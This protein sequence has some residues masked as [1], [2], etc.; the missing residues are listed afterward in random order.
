MEA[1]GRLVNSVSVRNDQQDISRDFNPISTFKISKINNGSMGTTTFS[2][3]K[4]TRINDLVLTLST[5]SFDTSDLKNAVILNYELYNSSPTKSFSDV[6]FGIFNDWDIGD[7][8]NNSSR[9]NSEENMLYIYEDSPSNEDIVSVVALNKTSSALAI[10]NNF[11]GP[12]SST[13]FEIN[14]EFTRSEKRKSLKAGTE[15][16]VENNVD[17]SSVVASGPYYIAPNDKIS[18]GF[19]YA[20]GNTLNELISVVNAARNLDLIEISDINTNP[21]LKFPDDF[22]VFEN[23]PNPFN[24]KT[25]IRFK[26]SSSSNVTL[27]V[28]NSIGRKVL[29]V[30]DEGLSAGI[31]TY[32]I[33]MRNF[34][35]GIYYARIITDTDTKTIPLT[36]IK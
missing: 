28:Y 2:P 5:Y 23:Y 25:N 27:N 7:Y 32:P 10:D 24:P 33:D 6:Y 34:S 9:Y 20:Y 31:H 22:F 8:S 1:N 26:L 17:I 30:I 36:L 19:V 15:F 29:T 14:E 13:Q 11:P 3:L 21:D 4:T 35:S 18:I 12:F 16:S